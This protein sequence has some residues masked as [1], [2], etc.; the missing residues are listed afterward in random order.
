MES[1]NSAVSYRPRRA[2][3]LLALL[4]AL[5]L[6]PIG[7]LVGV[8]TVFAASASDV[9]VI[10][11]VGFSTLKEALEVAQDGQTIRLLTNIEYFESL[12]IDGKSLTFDVGSYEL[13]VSTVWQNAIQ[14]NDGN[15]W[16]DDSGGGELNAHC[17]GP[18]SYAV[19]VTGASSSAT[20]TSANAHYSAVVVSM[21]SVTVKGDATAT[22]LDADSSG[23]AIDARHGARVLIMGNVAATSLGVSANGVGTSVHVMGDAYGFG[24]PTQIVGTGAYAGSGSTVV[25]DGDAIGEVYG[26]YTMNGTI[27]VG[28]NAEGGNPYLG[29]QGTGILAERAGVALVYG[30]VKGT[31][32]GAK[33]SSSRISIVGNVLVENQRSDSSELAVYAL[34]G[35]NITVAG[36]VESNYIGVCADNW[37]SFV[38]IRGSVTADYC[39]AYARQSATIQIDGSILSCRYIGIDVG[40]GCLVTVSG[41]VRVTLSTEAVPVTYGVF[42]QYGTV[43]IGGNLTAGIGVFADYGSKINVTGDI[44]ANL[45]GVHVDNSSQATIDGAIIVSLTA[46]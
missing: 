3:K 8:S 15:L 22:S 20:V 29:V 35:G 43:E 7:Q 41:D 23:T 16:L 5:V 42:G 39:A 36:N 11:S 10:G 14:V 12:V 46:Q 31:W 19:S 13:Y 24:K 38:Q 33:A 25:V 37:G 6:M 28:G 18:Y 40:G 1:I 2:S 45:V 26:A 44:T 17:S 21:G 27:T 32:Q 34:D 9:S 4:L 30:N